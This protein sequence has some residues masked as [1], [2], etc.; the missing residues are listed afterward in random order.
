MTE[1]GGAAGT[2]GDGSELPPDCRSWDSGFVQCE[3]CGGEYV[4]R[5]GR[6]PEELE[7]HILPGD[8]SGICPPPEL[9][10]FEA[11]DVERPKYERELHMIEWDPE[12]IEC[13]YFVAA[14]ESDVRACEEQK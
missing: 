4:E 2:G 13:W 11:F 14:S 5:W 7:G 12:H 1:T 9:V 10:D 3:T 6:F 8:Y